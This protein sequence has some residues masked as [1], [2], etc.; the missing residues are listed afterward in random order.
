MTTN[1]FTRPIPARTGYTGII[2]AV[3]ADLDGP[4]APRPDP[5]VVARAKRRRFTA[6]YKRRILAEADAARSRRGRFAV[7]AGRVVLVPSCLVAEGARAW[8]RG[9]LTPQKR[10]P[11]AMGEGEAAVS[12]QYRQLKRDWD[13][14]VERLRHAPRWASP[15]LLSTGGP[16]LT[17]RQAGCPSERRSSCGLFPVPSGKPSC[18]GCARSVFETFPQPACTRRCLTRVNTNCSIR[19]MCGFWRRRG[20]PRTAGPAGPS[21]IQKGG[22]AGHQAQR[23]LELRYHQAQGAHVDLLVP[24]RHH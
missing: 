15:V 4:P 11:K 8:N 10:G 2:D 20:N 22:V 14:L 9:A 17:G 21:S 12:E 23:T 19:T 16:V 24:L 3:L 18:R 5:E 7:A 6:E 1:G 13:R